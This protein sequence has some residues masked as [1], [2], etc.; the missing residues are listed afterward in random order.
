MLHGLKNP[1]GEVEALS[2]LLLD[3]SE[4]R[5]SHG[6]LKAT[7]FVMSAE[8]PVILDLDGMREHKNHDSFRRAF[9]RDV[10]RFM[11]NWQDH[12]ELA[13]RFEGLLSDLSR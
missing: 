3:L 13:D 11:K 7:N 6:D 9:N 10:D 12:P 5:I 8:G 2:S 4:S 1:H